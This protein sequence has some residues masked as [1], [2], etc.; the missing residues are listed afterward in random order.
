MFKDVSSHSVTSKEAPG[1]IQAVS[2]FL[3]RE[4]S[5]V[6]RDISFSFTET[7]NFQEHLKGSLKINGSLGAMTAYWIAS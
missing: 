2:L 1:T 4:C 5:G 3:R 7:L 6:L